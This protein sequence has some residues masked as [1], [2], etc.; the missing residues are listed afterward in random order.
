MHVRLC[1]K[2]TVSQKKIPT[3]ISL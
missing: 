1:V 3:I 2:Y